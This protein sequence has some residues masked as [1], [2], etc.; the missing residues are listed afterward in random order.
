[1]SSCNWRPEVSRNILTVRARKYKANHSWLTTLS[2]AIHIIQVTTSNL[3]RNE[4]NL[5]KVPPADGGCEYSIRSH[6]QHEIKERISPWLAGILVKLRTLNLK[7]RLI[8][9]GERLLYQVWSTRIRRNIKY[10]ARQEGDGIRFDS[11][12]KRPT[13]GNREVR[14]PSAHF[15]AF[16]AVSITRH[17][18]KSRRWRTGQV[19]KTKEQ[20]T[21]ESARHAIKW[22]SK[23]TGNVVLCT[24]IKNLKHLGSPKYPVESGVTT[25]G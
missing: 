2:A 9:P 15:Q 4:P 23:C 11:E 18:G 17:K 25:K 6:C 21:L 16:S 5:N 14:H 24:L 12:G 19:T 22:H 1:M 20:T 8:L 13:L 10:T 3:S 7:T